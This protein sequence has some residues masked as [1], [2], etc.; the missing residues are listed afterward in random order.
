MVPLFGTSICTPV[1]LPEITFFYAFW[2]PVIVT[3][4]LFCGLV[5]FK[6][7][8]GWR[9]QENLLDAGKELVAVLIR[10]SIFYFLV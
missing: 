7:V 8:R 6:A 1:N 3:E 2:I 4:T 5:I 9:R 10:D